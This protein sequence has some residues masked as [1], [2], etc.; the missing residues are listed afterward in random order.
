[1]MN[2]AP[3]KKEVD[4]QNETFCQL[5]ISINTI[6]IEFEVIYLMSPCKQQHLLLVPDN[7][8][9]PLRGFHSVTLK[10][11][12]SSR[13]GIHSIAILSFWQKTSS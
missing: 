13:T 5:F 4:V 8:D 3:G 10:R 9:N 1:M 12:C 2:R 6:L 7:P 11:R